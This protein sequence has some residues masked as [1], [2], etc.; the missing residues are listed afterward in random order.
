MGK[1]ILIP[2]VRQHK[3]NG[4]VPL[5]QALAR[6]VTTHFI[7]NWNKMFD[8]LTQEFSTSKKIVEFHIHG[9]SVQ[10]YKSQAIEISIYISTYIRTWFK[11]K[12][13]HTQDLN[14]KKQVGLHTQ[15]VCTSK[16]KRGTT[17][18]CNLHT[19]I[20][21]WYKPKILHS[22]DIITKHNTSAINK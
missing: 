4:P 1:I 17:N 10:A 19:Y 3:K 9:N 14:T 5:I 13:L 11:P 15:E 7:L 6:V 12:I 20:R 18:R 22:Q 2:A 21:T 8:L 16:K